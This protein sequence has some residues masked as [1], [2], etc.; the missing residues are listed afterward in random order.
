MGKFSLTKASDPEKWDLWVSGSNEGTIFSTSNYLAGVDGCPEL[1]YVLKAEEVCAGVAVMK[2]ANGYGALH[3]HVIYNGVMFAKDRLN[4]NFSQKNSDQFEILSFVAE[5]LPCEMEK[6]QMSFS[7]RMVDMRPF[8]WHNYGGDKEKKWTVDLRY[9]SFVDIRGCAGT[10]LEN[11]PLFEK[12]GRS[13]RQEIRYA[14][15]DGVV[16]EKSMDLDILIDLY[17]RTMKKG[18][19][20]TT[21]SQE[22][23]QKMK[24]LLNQIQKT[25]R[26]EQFIIRNERGEAVS[27]AFFCFDEKRAYFLF[28]GNHPDKISS[29]SGTIVLWDAFLFLNEAGFDEVDLEGVNSPK[30]GWF[31][32]SLGGNLTP[33]YQVSYGWGILDPG[34]SIARFRK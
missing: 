8:L 24:A 7:P 32:M 29:Y 4:Q 25:N 11:N 3:D 19:P 28:G 30:R 10:D 27:A 34:E 13:R 21:V 5:I 18:G 12:L 26:G 1:Y 33:Y 20:V 9:T 17:D 2:D 6:V 22:H 31:K 23:L 14:R 15:R 16:A